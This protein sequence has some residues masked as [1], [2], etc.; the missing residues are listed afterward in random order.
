[1]E[2]QAVEHIVDFIHTLQ[3]AQVNG[4]AIAA[5]ESHAVLI[6]DQPGRIK[7]APHRGTQR[8]ADAVLMSGLHGPVADWHDPL[9]LQAARLHAVGIGILLSI[10]LYVEPR[11]GPTEP[12]VLFR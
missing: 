7:N 9:V 4:R 6:F 11:A 8:A 1:M 12:A 10:G 3:K 2:L 5:H